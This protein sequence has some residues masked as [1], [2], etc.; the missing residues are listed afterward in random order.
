MRNLR[1]PFQKLLACLVIF[2]AISGGAALAQSQSDLAEECL[3]AIE[4]GDLERVSELSSQMKDWK[5]LFGTKTISRA[6]LCLEAATGVEWEYFTTQGRFLSGSEAQDERDFIAGAAT[7]KAD[8]LSELQRLQCQIDIAAR[9]VES[10]TEGFRRFE[11]ARV[12]EA[13]R[14]TTETCSYLYT[15]DR[16]SAL[17]E[18]VCNEIFM[19]VGLPDSEFE[20]D[21]WE[22][23]SS[24]LALLAANEELRN[25]RRSEGSTDIEPV[26]E[27]SECE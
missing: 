22:L 19:K 17:L 18:P 5:S 8:N 3:A 15:E 9:K 26:I 16:N 23:E 12:G 24:R 27:I 7:R 4:A 10:L 2:S 25:F 6:E 13:L 11:Q 14:V 1:F 21:Y 20:F